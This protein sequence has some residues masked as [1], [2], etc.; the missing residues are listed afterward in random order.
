MISS[1][2]LEESAREITWCANAVSIRTR[3]AE[4]YKEFRNNLVTQLCQ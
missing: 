1:Y 4:L 3:V 2:G